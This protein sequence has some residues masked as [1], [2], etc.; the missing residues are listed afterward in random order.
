MFNRSISDTKEG[1]W[2][3]HAHFGRQRLEKWVFV[4]FRVM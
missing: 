2:Q 1:L 4:K 3:R